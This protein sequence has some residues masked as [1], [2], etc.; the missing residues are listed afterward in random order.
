MVSKFN[1]YYFKPKEIYF[2]T[3]QV[4]ELIISFRLFY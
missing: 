4:H 2:A 3:T 1:N